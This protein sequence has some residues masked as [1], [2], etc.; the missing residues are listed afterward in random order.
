MA[1]IN[2]YNQIS[3]EH[4]EIRAIGKLSDI[5]PDFDFTHSIILRAGERVTPDVFL[6][7]DDVIYLRVI[8]GSTAVVATIAIVSAVIAVGVGI[9]AAIYANQQSEEAKAKMEKAQRD[10][11]N[12]A[13]QINQLPFL[14]GAK[15]K[16]ALGNSIQYLIG[17]M[18]NTPYLLT[19]GFYTIAGAD[20]DKQFWNAI[21][22]LGYG[23]QKIKNVSIGNVK[24]KDFGDGTVDDVVTSFD[25]PTEAVGNPYYDDETIIEIAQQKSLSTAIFKNKVISTQ[26]GTEI[27]HD[28]G[29]EAEPVI[30]QC[31]ERTKTLEVCI[32]FNGL[33]KYNT[34]SS[35]WEN[36]NVKIDPY[37]SNDN[38]TTW[39]KFY[40]AFPGQSSWRVCDHDE[41]LSLIEEGKIQPRETTG[42]RHYYSKSSDV[43]VKNGLGDWG[44]KTWQPM[45]VEQL[46]A[47][48]LVSGDNTL[49]KNTNKTIRYVARK[50]FTWAET[51][52]ENGN[53]LPIIFKVEKV[54]PKL[55]SNSTEDCYLLYYNCY[56]YDGKLSNAE[57]GLVDCKPMSDWY[58]GKCSFI[59]V[60]MVANES[61]HDVLDEINVIASGLARTWNG[62]E[63]SEEK[64][65]TRN[66]ASWILELLTSSAHDHS[67][68]SDDEIDL[69]SL[70][71][72]YEYC[73]ENNFCV[74]TIL[75]KGDKKNTIISNI[76]ST[77]FASMYL[78]AESGKLTFAIDREENTPVALLNSQCIQSITV[79][80]SFERKPDGIKANFTNRANWQI[81]TRYCM[82]DGSDSHSVED[83]LTELSLEY[84]TN[85][86]HVYKVAQ[87]KMRMERLQPRE[88]KVKVGR[89]G[90]YY[91]LYSIVLLQLE[92]LKQGIRSSVIESV[93]VFNNQIVNIEIGDWV[94]F[95]PGY[96]YGVVIQCENEN[97]F[98]LRNCKVTG[99][100]KTRTLTLT[101]PIPLSA[102]GTLPQAKNILSFGLLDDDGE[103]SKVTNT[104][105]I[106]G[107]NSSDDG[108]ELVLKD[109]NEAVYSFGV[110]PEYKSN[111]TN[112]P[113]KLN[114]VSDI[115]F[116][117]E[118]NE[119]KGKIEEVEAKEYGGSITQLSS[120]DPTG[121]TEG[122]LGLYEHKFYRL[123]NGEWRE[124]TSEQYL[125][126]L[127]TFPENAGE[128]A[129]FLMADD[130]AKVLNTSEGILKVLGKKLKIVK[131]NILGFLYVHKGEEWIKITDKNDYRYVLAMNDMA[132]LGL[133]VPFYIK[134]QIID[135]VVEYVP[136][137]LG[138]FETVPSVA[139]V[140]D[141]FAFTGVSTARYTR[142]TVYTW[143]GTEWEVDNND[144]HKMQALN[145]LLAITETVAGEAQFVN[146]FVDK[147]CANEAFIEKLVAKYVILREGGF[148]KSS[149][150]VPDDEDT[151]GV[152]I[153]TDGNAT[154]KGE[155]EIGGTLKVNGNANFGSNSS[156]YGTLKTPTIYSS[157]KEI[158]QSFT[159]IEITNIE[160]IKN[161]LSGTYT[162]TYNGETIVSMEVG[163]TIDAIDEHYSAGYGNWYSVTLTTYCII[164]GNRYSATDTYGDRSRWDTEEKA[165]KW[166]ENPTTIPQL[167]IEFTLIGSFSLLTI[168][169][170]TNYDP[171]VK[172][173][174]YRDNNFNLLISN[175]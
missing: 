52:D 143:N 170:V 175:G 7:D 27:K 106:Y 141:W 155:T 39:N 80:K 140:G 108:V 74:D 22:C 62:E 54:T 55:E 153:D 65:E 174:I 165:R 50:E 85:P 73:D 118:L 13:S 161:V 171:H 11:D 29:G 32:Q 78:D 60:Q 33:R 104:M 136:V 156:F 61:T 151:K 37:W 66:P 19:D 124:L 9:G 126:K 86:D 3:N 164:N 132:S 16:G 38:G 57:D 56:C 150:F 81:D 109:Y 114:A 17:E 59:G 92:Q 64:E 138:A 25:A 154:F 119:L 127:T 94:E 131:E 97:G 157:E 139:N 111:L 53:E 116:R 2:I 77:C 167:N 48:I 98:T 28:F 79:A 12:L 145:D 158:S 128:D 159:S 30:K 121:F 172:G 87:R 5:L 69:N 8:P 173:A 110:I 68:Y 125:G 95:V 130:G 96:N 63:W 120:L 160:T 105:K 129:Y 6:D 23:K 88:V 113:T 142:G 101:V 112:P 152:F 166:A 93:G 51:H 89:E 15:N 71:E 133:D 70:G 100:G 115:S 102:S 147:L 91:P 21:L 144:G 49:S 84:V 44:T 117:G 135:S 162:G 34:S 10:A 149:N 20:G 4:K 41:V 137:Y 42:L 169:T 46:E 148:L 146:A 168:G 82:L 163:Y 72:L 122:A 24:V 35:S 67:K 90:D 134:Q 43:Q 103:F 47:R 14:K 31:A 1:L 76:L 107:I 123:E 40:F 75:T 18:Y 36:R 83:M 58:T 26:D 99:S 45:S